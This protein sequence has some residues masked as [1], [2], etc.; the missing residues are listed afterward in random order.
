L[1]CFRSSIEIEGN[2]EEEDDFNSSPL[3]RKILKN[4]QKSSI[5]VIVSETKKYLSNESFF[6][7]C[8]ILRLSNDFYT[9]S[10][11]AVCRYVEE[12]I[13]EQLLTL[14][15]IGN[16]GFNSMILP[17]FCVISN[18]LMKLNMKNEVK[19]ILQEFMMFSRVIDVS[20]ANKTMYYFI[21]TISRLSGQHFDVDFSP[22]DF[23]ELLEFILNNQDVSFFHYAS[24]LIEHQKNVDKSVIKRVI[25]KSVEILNSD[26]VSEM[27][28]PYAF[29]EILIK[30]LKYDFRPWVL[31]SIKICVAKL[32]DLLVEPPEET[33]DVSDLEVFTI[34]K[35]LIAV[36][37][38][39]CEIYISKYKI[40]P[41]MIQ[42]IK[43]EVDEVRF[44]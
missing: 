7:A 26:K 9:R 10:F 20:L 22:I 16:I 43:L 27:R 13:I 40:V 1:E 4:Y 41:L 44:L 14:L 18:D 32:K 24:T 2:E 21:M 34:L 6:N 30:F 42:F 36:F 23:G 15:Q 17:V 25:D 35:T 19:I 39:D 12:G 11:E 37:R 38:E 8:V 5:D 28:N 31:E 29:F 3:I 33:D